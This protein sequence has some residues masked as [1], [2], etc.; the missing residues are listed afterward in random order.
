MPITADAKLIAIAIVT[1]AILLASV[2]LL[3]KSDYET[4][5]AATRAAYIQ[6]APTVADKPLFD[7]GITKQCSGIA[8]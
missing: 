5:M 6:A 7:L 4:C 1:A 3:K 8:G 2:Q